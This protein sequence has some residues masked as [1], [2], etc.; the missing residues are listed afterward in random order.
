MVRWIWSIKIPEWYSTNEL[1]EKLKLKSVQEHIVSFKMVWL[2]NKN[3]G[4]MLA[5]NHAKLQWSRCV[6][7]TLSSKK[8]MV[9]QHW[10][11]HEQQHENQCQTSIQPT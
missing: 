1:R 11:R 5:K 4:W 7:Q 3:E 2:L 9:E 8:M 10:Q 6:L